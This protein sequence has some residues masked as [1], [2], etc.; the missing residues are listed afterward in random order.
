[1]ASIQRVGVTGKMTVVLARI[2]GLN[3]AT[4]QAVLHLAFYALWRRNDD[5]LWCTW[6]GIGNQ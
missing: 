1:M 4:D 3:P 6:L 2:P 5:C